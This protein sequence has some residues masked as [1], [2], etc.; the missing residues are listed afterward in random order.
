MFREILVSDLP[1][2]KAEIARVQ[3]SLEAH[4]YART[5]D[6]ALGLPSDLHH[7]I[8]NYFFKADL[9]GPEKPGL[10]PHDRIRVRDVVEYRRQGTGAL[11]LSEYSRIT[12]RPVVN[13][14]TPREYNRVHSLEVPWFAQW[15]AVYL[16]LMPQSEQQAHGTLGLDFFR[17]FTGVAAYKHQDLEQFI[18]VYVADRQTKGVV[19]SLHPIEN[20]EE[21]LVAATLMP[22]EHLIFRDRDFMHDATP[23]QPRFKGDRPHR[24]AIVTAVHYPTT[25]LEADTKEKGGQS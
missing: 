8:D 10:P 7:Q 5:S 12:M 19:T 25:Y 14:L 17:T 22:G 3:K 15:I 18:G 4:G 13:V 11:A 1:V 9:L 21:T 20:P 24:D 16:S 2:S 23:L 6:G